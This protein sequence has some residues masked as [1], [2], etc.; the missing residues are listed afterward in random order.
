LSK[1]KLDQGGSNLT[2]IFIK[3]TSNT[4]KIKLLS[5]VA[6]LAGVAGHQGVSLLIKSRILDLGFQKLLPSRGVFLVITSLAGRD[7]VTPAMETKEL[8]VNGDHMVIRHTLLIDR[9]AT[10]AASPSELGKESLT[11][12]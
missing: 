4:L 3:I 5:V 1:S 9:S 12:S 10:V 2:Y 8:L 7:D 11:L 6:I